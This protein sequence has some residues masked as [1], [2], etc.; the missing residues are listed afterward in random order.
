ML[1]LPHAAGANWQPTQG[2][3]E[4]IPS[5][6]GCWQMRRS[7]S[8][9]RTTCAPT[10]VAS[11]GRAAARRLVSRDSDPSRGSPLLPPG[12]GVR[13]HAWFA[14]AA[15][16]APTPK[17]AALDLQPFVPSC[18]KA[19]MRRLRT[20]DLPDIE[21]TSASNAMTVPSPACLEYDAC[22]SPERS[23]QPSLPV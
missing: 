14:V 13:R 18:V 23:R 20:H 15:R 2:S 10:R 4:S 11:R 19:S 8:R 6:R 22:S 17:P 5:W 9:P 21:I 1:W 16:A 12:C 3:A 7:K